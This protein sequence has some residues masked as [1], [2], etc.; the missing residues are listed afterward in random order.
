MGR[1]A[2]PERTSPAT[3]PSG[4][5]AFDRAAADFMGR[6]AEPERTSPATAKC[7]TEPQPTS[8]FCEGQRKPRIFRKAGVAISSAGSRSWADE[9]VRWPAPLR[10]L[11]E[12]HE[13][14]GFLEPVVRAQGD[15]TRGK[16]VV[17]GVSE[18]ALGDRRT[19]VVEIPPVEAHLPA[20]RP[21]TEARG[22]GH[23]ITSEGR[24]PLVQ[25]PAADV[26]HLDAARP[27]IVRGIDE[28]RGGKV[29]GGHFLPVSAQLRRRAVK[30]PGAV[31]I[32]ELRDEVPE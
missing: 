5:E 14:S 25:E 27:S 21:V 32:V 15:V 30:R 29:A 23:V 16:P 31:R 17:L 3:A 8:K 2:E 28:G 4:S 10:L 6:P 18:L 24:V 11:A 22:P 20:L 1:P 26:V 7:P 12:V 19:L 9:P 13:T